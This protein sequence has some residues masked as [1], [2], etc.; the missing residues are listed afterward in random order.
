[1]SRAPGASWFRVPPWCMAMHTEEAA[2]RARAWVY[3]LGAWHAGDDPSTREVRRVT[4]FGGGRADALI[5]EVGRWAQ[6]SGAAVPA[7][8][9]GR[10]AKSTGAVA[11]HL[12]GGQTEGQRQLSE[13]SG[14]LT[15]QK[16]GGSRAR[17]PVLFREKELELPTA[18]ASTAGTT[19]P[20]PEPT[21]E[22]NHNTTPDPEPQP[23]RVWAAMSALR[24]ASLP[25]AEPLV[26][27]PAFRASL[28]ARLKEFGEARV[29]LAWRWVLTCECGNPKCLAKFLR[30]GGYAHPSTFLRPSKCGNYVDKASQEVAAGTFVPHDIA[31]LT[32]EVA[33][34]IEIVARVART[35]HPAAVP[36]YSPDPAENRRL[37]LATN[38]AGGFSAFH[39]GPP[40]PTTRQR[41]AA[42]YT[43]AHP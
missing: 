9:P 1:M 31:P 12:R 5:R 27:T 38:A 17:D 23:A 29:M 35:C 8:L 3:L 14:A 22:P 28:R 36:V 16:R 6:D 21:P 33:A 20:D 10:L 30:D 15:G 37:R 2:T 25:G 26:L 4:G 32:P 13:D 11:G 24:V 41:F 39:P 18:L 40:S 7:S 42:A 34:A 43:G 19:T